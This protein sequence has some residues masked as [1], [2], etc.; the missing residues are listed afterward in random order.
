MKSFDVLVTSGQPGSWE[1]SCP[2][3]KQNLNESLSKYYI[4]KHG[5]VFS[6]KQM[7]INVMNLRRCVANIRTSLPAPTPILGKGGS[8][9]PLVG[10]S[11]WLL[12]GGRVWI[13]VGGNI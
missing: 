7:K 3:M 12:V 11:I 9:L 13:L 1:S 4:G 8:L 5:F 2:V 10:G 6:N